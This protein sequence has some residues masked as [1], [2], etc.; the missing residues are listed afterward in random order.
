[1]T[2]PQ[3]HW[4]HADIEWF[5]GEVESRFEILGMPD[6]AQQVKARMTKE[7]LDL[8][9]AIVA[10]LA[11][12]GESSAE[13]KRDASSDIDHLVYAGYLTRPPSLVSLFSADPS[14]RTDPAVLCLLPKVGVHDEELLGRPDSGVSGARACSDFVRRP[15]VLHGCFGGLPGDR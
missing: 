15:E 5:A 14:T 7:I 8:Y 11:M 3:G 2:E 12:R 1:M 13:I 10:A 9:R 4:E 6:T